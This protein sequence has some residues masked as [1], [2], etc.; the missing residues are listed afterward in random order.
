MRTH[1]MSKGRAGQAWDPAREEGMH[2]QQQKDRAQQEGCGHRGASKLPL[3]PGGGRRS[4][5]SVTV[6]RASPKLGD[7]AAN[8]GDGGG[9]SRAHR[10]RGDRTDPGLSRP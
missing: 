8:R 10:H 5:R 1:V 2:R 3:Q 7:R 9:S 4:G 6:S